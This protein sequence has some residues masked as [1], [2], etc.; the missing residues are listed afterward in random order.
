MDKSVEVSELVHSLR[1]TSRRLEK[2]NA[3]GSDAAQSHNGHTFLMPV[4]PAQRRL[5]TKEQAAI[6]DGLPAP[7]PLLDNQG[8]IV[9]FMRRGGALPA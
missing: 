6:L 4:L 1:E 3:N 5:E 8:F 7:S 2:A 9:A